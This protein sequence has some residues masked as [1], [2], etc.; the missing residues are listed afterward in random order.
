VKKL[1]FLGSFCIC[2]ELALQPKGCSLP[3][4]W[5]RPTNGTRLSK[6]AGIKLAKAFRQ[7]YD[8]N[9]SVTPTDLY[10]FGDRCH[11]EHSQVPAALIR[12]W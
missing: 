4:H 8:A 11:P 1:L 12:D 9:I 2:P 3:D 5:S 6:I 7:R 10:G